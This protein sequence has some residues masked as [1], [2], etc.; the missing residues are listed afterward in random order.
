LE[1]YGAADL[2]L[3]GLELPRVLGLR[4]DGWLE[5]SVPGAEPAPPEVLEVIADVHGL[6]TAAQKELALR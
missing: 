4:F 5:P 1:K 2:D 6:L 3:F